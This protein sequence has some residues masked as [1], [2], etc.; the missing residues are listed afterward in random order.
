MSWIPHITVAAI[1]EREG[2]FLLVEELVE[3]TPVYNQPAG[4][5]EENESLLDAVVREAFEE[6]GLQFTPEYLIGVYHWQQANSRET[7]IRFA[8][9]GLSQEGMQPIKLSKGILGTT[10]LSREKITALPQNKLRSSMVLHCINDY[11]EGKRYPLSVLSYIN[12]RK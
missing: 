8:F 9:A 2:R 5:L 3:D 7:Y 1:S 6:T 4:H 10:W 11:C 12:E